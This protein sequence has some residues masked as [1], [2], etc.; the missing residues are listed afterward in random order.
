VAAERPREGERHK[1]AA[2]ATILDA[3]AAAPQEPATP[4]REP[5]PAEDRAPAVAS[6]T[7]G[8]EPELLVEETAEAIV[9]ELEATAEAIVDPGS[10]APVP[11]FILDDIARRDAAKS[12]PTGG[13]AAEDYPEGSATHQESRPP[14][15]NGA[16]SAGARDTDAEDDD[17]EPGDN[18]SG[19]EKRHHSSSGSSPHGMP[20][21]RAVRC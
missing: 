4:P 16:K 1:R 2:T 5:E 17:G 12:Q 21:R 8:N 18:G 7:P 9:A 19:Y 3:M 6:F 11:A 13:A 20:A 15:G 10:P 14:G